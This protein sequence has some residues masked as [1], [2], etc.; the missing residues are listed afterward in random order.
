LKVPEIVELIGL[1]RPQGDATARRLAR[2]HDIAG[3]RAAARRVRPRAVFD[4]VDG[5]A[6]EEITLAGNEAALRRYRFT[7]ANV[8]NVAAP[9]PSVE[10]FGA[11]L[12]LP[13]ILAPTGYTRMMHPQGELAVSRAARRAGLPYT[14]ST[15]ASTSLEEL[16]T[17]DHPNRWFQLYIWRDRTMTHSLVERAWQAGYGALEVSIDVPVAGQRL[18]DVRNGLTIPPMLTARTLLDIAIHPG[19]W[20]SMLRSPP[21]AFANAPPAL[22]GTGGVTIENMSAQFD[23]SVTWEDVAEIRK[24]WPGKL[25]VKGPLVPA[26]VPRALDAGVDGLHLSNHGGRQLDRLPASIDMLP[27]LRDAAGDEVPI[28]FDSGVRHGADI[29]VALALGANAV[30]VGRAYLYGLMAG[31]ERGVD[32]V[33]ELLGAELRRTMALLG[34]SSTEEIRVSGRELLT[35][36]PRASV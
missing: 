14:L 35:A 2:C 10:L 12:P 5:A 1:R 25:L 28:I 8:R 34:V 18:R 20:V 30:A 23:P 21:L 36:E 17:S 24:L 11:S 22:D 26:D 13:L 27:A 32:R 7:P 33:L 16:A 6:D 4:Y 31:G 29:V 9:D 19:Y 3:L 15:V